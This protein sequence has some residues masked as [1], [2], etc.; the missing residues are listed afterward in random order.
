[1]GFA[2]LL[3]LTGGS[4]GGS[5]SGSGFRF[6]GNAQP[7]RFNFSTGRWGEWIR[8]A[9]AWLNQN[10]APYFATKQQALQTS[11]WIF[12]G[13]VLISIVVALLLALVR[14]PAETA[15]IRM[16]DGYEVDGTR[17]KFAQGWRLGW[18]QR[19]FHMWVV[20]LIL[21]VPVI[22]FVLVLLGGILLA[23]STGY[24][25][26]QV[27]AGRPWIFLA[28]PFGLVLLVLFLGMVFLGILRPFFIRAVVLEDATIGEAFRR[29]WHVFAVN[30]KD[31]LLLWLVLVGVGLAVGIAMILVFFILIP[32]YILLALP[33]ALV[34]AIPGAVAY[35]I[36]ALFNPQVLPWIIGAVAALPFFFLVVFSPLI[37]LGGLV[38]LYLSTN[39]TLAYRQF[40]RREVP[41]MESELPPALVE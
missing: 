13:I 18:S 23:I 41:P 11:L 32:V 40:T 15:I 37:F 2:F 29:G 26:N 24:A 34:A 6:S 9:E 39:W 3:A 8:E 27:G 20:D 25:N 17:L 31:S 10:V 35:G 19:A 28:I 33:G 36:T 16:V 21:A 22:I 1:V 12:V 30:V 4:A 5:N 14:Y 38:Q 7:G